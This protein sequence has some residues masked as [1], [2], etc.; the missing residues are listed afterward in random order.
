MSVIQK[1]TRDTDEVFET[2]VAAPAQAFQPGPVVVDI[3][4]THDEFIQ[5]LTMRAL[6]FLGEQESPWGEEFDNEFSCT[7]VL[8]KVAGEPAGALRIRWFANFAKIERLSVR[9][10]FRTGGKAGARHIADALAGFA[11]ELIRRKGYRQMVGHAQK[12]LYPFWKRHGYQATGEEIVYADHT[13]V[14]MV[15]HLEPHPQAIG[16]DADPMV[17]IRPEGRW[18]EPGP[19]DLS[20]MRPA[21]CPHRDR[22][23]RE[24][25]AA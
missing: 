15:G 9:S 4:R 18:D 1:T 22:R 13:Y 14:L 10:E 3:V 12:R 7:H 8:C 11:V 5:A 20:M 21:T 16:V 17:V 23:P 6:S 19:F 25:R 2:S 24:A